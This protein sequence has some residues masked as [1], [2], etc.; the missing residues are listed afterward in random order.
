MKTDIYRLTDIER[1]Q[2]LKAP[3]EQ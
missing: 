1:L 3:K 2:C